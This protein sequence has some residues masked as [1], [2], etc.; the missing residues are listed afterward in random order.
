MPGEYLVQRDLKDGAELALALLHVGL[1]GAGDGTG[2]DPAAL[3]AAALRRTLG[4]GLGRGDLELV[5]RLGRLDEAGGRYG[6]WVLVERVAVVAFDR[7]AAALDAVDPRLGPS[8]L[9]HVLDCT[10][11]A[12]AFTPA[13]AVDFVRMFH[14][15][16]EDDDGE[17]MN[18]ARYDLAHERNCDPDLIPGEEVAAAAQDYGLTSAVVDGR[19]ERRYQNPGTLT[20]EACRQ[21]CERHGLERALVAVGALE[22]LRRLGDAL[23]EPAPELFDEDDHDPFGVLLTLGGDFDLT[24]ELYGEYEDSTWN[25]GVGFRPS[26]AVAFSPDDADSLAELEAAL[27]SCGEVLGQLGVLLRAI[28]EV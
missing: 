14:W 18:L 22:R 20:L 25:S 13:L 10:P 28:E 5:F 7:A 27:R 16:G 15:H 6:L 4:D 17:L 24:R 19:L 21:L 2:E 12:P 26:F 9:T 23:P 8:L 3:I 11:L 1:V